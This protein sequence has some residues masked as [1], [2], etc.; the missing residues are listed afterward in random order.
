MEA[1]GDWRKFLATIPIIIFSLVY[2]DLVSGG[3]FSWLKVESYCY[4]NK[5]EYRA[6]NPFI[7]KLA[8]DILGGVDHVWYR[9]YLSG[10]ISSERTMYIS[11]LK[12]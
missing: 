3:L 7:S 5:V 10:A 11:P 8:A 2:Q 12:G 9:S 6:W 4:E 1:R